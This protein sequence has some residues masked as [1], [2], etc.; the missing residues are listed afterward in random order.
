MVF[1]RNFLFF[2]GWDLILIVSTDCGPFVDIIIIRWLVQCGDRD[3]SP[4]SGFVV[5]KLSLCSVFVD[6]GFGVVLDLLVHDHFSILQIGGSITI[7]F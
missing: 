1:V 4:F 3:S 7:G 6:G 2:D 5:S